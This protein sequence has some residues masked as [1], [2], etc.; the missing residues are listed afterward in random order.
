MNAVVP[1]ETNPQIRRRPVR[2]IGQPVPTGAPFVCAWSA[3]GGCVIVRVAGEVDDVSAPSLDLELRRVITTKQ[4]TV[5]VDLRR[6]S[7]MTSAG[8]HALA[9]AH[10]LATEHDGWLRLACASDQLL[11]LIRI[12]GLDQR[13]EHHPRLA[14][15]LPSYRPSIAGP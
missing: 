2:S 14:D 11:R 7:L 10:A 12:T 15:A 8:I 4:P 3:V 9:T 1:F 5:V 6:V 13:V